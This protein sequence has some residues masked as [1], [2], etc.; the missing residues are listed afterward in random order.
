MFQSVW[1]FRSS[2]KC[3]T[4]KRIL[5][6]LSTGEG[7]VRWGLHISLAAILEGIHISKMKQQIHDKLNVWRTRKNSEPQMGF[8]P[9]TLR[10]LVGCS[11]HWATGDSMVICL[12]EYAYHRDTHVTDRHQFCAFFCVRAHVKKLVY[13]HEMTVPLRSLEDSFC[14][15]GKWCSGKMS[16]DDFRRLNS[17]VFLVRSY[18]CLWQTLGVGNIQSLLWLWTLYVLSAT[19]T[20]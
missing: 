1:V 7:G 5:F 18:H 10:D 3:Q 6:I 11:N 16:T 13:K 2:C 4:T 9:T 20:S 17:D 8:E 14:T 15:T 12:R 19:H